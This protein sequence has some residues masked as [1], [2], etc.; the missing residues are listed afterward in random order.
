MNIIQTCF[1]K[2]SGGLEMAALKMSTAL[3]KKGHEVLALCLKNSFLEKEFSKS[4]IKYLSLS[5]NPISRLYSLKKLFK[6][7]FDVVHTHLSHDL[8]TLVPALNLSSNKIKLFL[9]KHMASGVVKKNFLYRKLYSRVN[10]IFAISEFI[11]INVIHTCP[12]SENNVYVLPVT[13]PMKEFNPDLYDIT[14]VRK[15]LG[16][17]MDTITVCMT[18][19]FT[20]GKGY[21]DF[22]EALPIISGNVSHKVVFFI[23]GSKSRSEEDYERKLLNKIKSLPPKI[24]IKLIGYQENIAKFFSAVDIL[25]FPSYEESF[26]SVVIEAMAM[27]CAVVA[28]KNAG[29]TDIITHGCDGLFY[30]VQNIEKFAGNIIELIKNPKLRKQ[31]GF[32][33]RKTAIAKFD[34]DLLIEK[35]EEIYNNRS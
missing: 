31:I 8:W 16:I 32:N 22:L 15:E 20:Y 27:E 18:G 3:R 34:L 9:S 6:S 21:E 11:K 7:D 1:S 29:V 30:P 33:A 26:G 4:E 28:A 13:V 35:Y 14:E 12:V 19:R 17:D 24:D 5:S 10:G 2:S 23:R 25:A